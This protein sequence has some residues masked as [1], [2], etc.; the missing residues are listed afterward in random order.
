MLA[1]AAAGPAAQ[2]DGSAAESMSALP[3]AAGTGTRLS[4]TEKRE[5]GDEVSPKP[6]SEKR[7]RIA[8]ER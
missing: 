4:A 7:R 1:G 5:I 6:T 8:D 3:S 2:A